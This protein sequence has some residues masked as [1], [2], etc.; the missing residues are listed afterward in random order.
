MPSVVG[1]AIV[2]CGLSSV[3]DAPCPDA[4]VRVAADDDGV[5]PRC[6]SKGATVTD[7]VL[8]IVDDNALE[9]PM[10]Q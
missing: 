4:V 2:H 7:V 9:D 5:V 3:G 10:E 8:D 6:P 1:L